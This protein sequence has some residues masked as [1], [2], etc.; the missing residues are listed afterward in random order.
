[1]NKLKELNLVV[2]LVLNLLHLTNELAQM[3]LHCGLC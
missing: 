3:A 1:M 2:L